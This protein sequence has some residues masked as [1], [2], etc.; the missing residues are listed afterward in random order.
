MCT[1]FC[2]SALNFKQNYFHIIIPNVM[3]HGTNILAI[4]EIICL[5]QKCRRDYG[6]YL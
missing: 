1:L 4:G 2:Y 3:A 6:K 5:V